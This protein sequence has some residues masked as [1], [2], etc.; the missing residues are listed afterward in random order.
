[1]R[2]ERKVF[3]IVKVVTFVVRHLTL[4]NKVGDGLKTLFW[5]EP[6]NGHEHLMSAFPDLF[7]IC[8]NHEAT[9][10]DT[11]TPQGWNICFRRNLNDWEI[12]R[13]VGL[14]KEVDKFKGISAVPD[15]I[16]WK[17]ISN[18]RFS[19]NRIY[20]T[21]AL[22]QPGGSTGPWLKKKGFQLVFRCFLCNEM[23]ETNS[24]LFLHCK[25][26]AQLWS[27]FFSLTSN[28]CIRSSKLLDQER[29]VASPRRDGG[30]QFLHVFGGQYGRKEMRG[31]LGQV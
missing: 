8:S 13:V 19:V 28:N 5:K 14:L 2:N 11:W 15:V 18:G 22:G 25:V 17:H 26:T 12:D 29:G 31:V 3:P 24:H 23:A 1:M 30:E 6:W 21:E 10:A 4:L 9:V 27:L 7:S 20:K 16:N